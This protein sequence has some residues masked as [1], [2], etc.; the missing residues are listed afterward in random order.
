MHTLQV[1]NHRMVC[2]W[3]VSQRQYALVRNGLTFHQANT[4][5]L[6]Q[7]G[8]LLDTCIS[9]SITAGQV[10]VP[11]S[12]TGLDQRHDRRVSDLGTV[13]QVDIVQVFAK[14]ANSQH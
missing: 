10:D 14:L 13:A 6:G 3:G 8:Q 1:A 9:Q 12:V 4:S 2:P 5:E 7:S 11:N